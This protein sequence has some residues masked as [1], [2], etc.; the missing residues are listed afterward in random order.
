[1]IGKSLP[2]A[3]LLLLLLLLAS[4]PAPG[5]EAASLYPP[6]PN[7]LGAAP[8]YR[9]VVAPRGALTRPDDPDFLAELERQ[10]RA[11]APHL[12]R[13]SGPTPAS[14]TG[15][16]AVTLVWEGKDPTG[17]LERARITAGIWGDRLVMLI[18]R[19]SAI[20]LR[21]HE[22]T[23]D[24]IVATIA[25]E[26]AS[27]PIAGKYVSDQMTVVLEK[28]A[29]GYGGRIEFAGQAM[30]LTAKAEGN[31]IEGSFETGGNRFPFTAVLEGDRLTLVSGGT[32]YALTREGGPAPGPAN[33]LA[34]GGPAAPVAPAPAP[35]GGVPTAL[36]DLGPPRADPKREWTI[37]VYLD[38]DNDLE[39]FA[40]RDIVE[41]EAGLPPSGI[42]V[43]VLVDRAKGFED[44]LGDWTDSRVYRVRPDVDPNRIASEVLA[45]PGELNMGDPKTL[46]TFMGAALRAFP[47]PN[48]MLI[49]WDHG[50]G[51]ASMASDFDAPGSAEGNDHLTL[52]EAAAGIRGGLARAG[53]EKLDM[54]GF[55]MCLMSQIE[56]AVELEG[57]A[58]VMVASQAIEPGNGWPYN[59]ILPVIAKGT[60]GS[61][62]VAQEIVRAYS[63]FYDAA[64]ADVATLS[65]LDLRVLPEVVAAFD[66]IVG[67]L[68]PAAPAQWPAFSRSI[69]YAEA[70]A[71]R[72]DIRR[73]PQALA[74]VDL[75]DVVKRLRY[76]TEGFA[77]EEEY[78][79]L[80]QAMD[81]F[82][83]ASHNSR[84]RR[85]SN[86]ISI[87][88]PV[89]GEMLDPAWGGTKFGGTSSWGQ[90]LGRIHA[91]Q[92]AGAS[93]PRLT[94]LRATDEK[95]NPIRAVE[96]MNNDR[97]SFD[98]EGNNIV[99]T[100]VWFG[101][102]DPAA[103]GMIV[104]TKGFVVDPLF[105]KRRTDAIADVVDLIMPK[106][107]DG[108]NS[109]YQDTNGLTLR[110]TDG[111]KAYE[112]TMDM[113]ALDDPDHI[114][115][116]VLM[117]HPSVGEFGGTVLFDSYWW[118]AR[119]VIAEIPQ[120][121]GRIAYRQIEPPPETRVTLLLETVTP[122][123]EVKYSRGAT[124]AWGK[125]LEL[126]LDVDA[127][128][129]Y[130]A[131]FIAETIGGQS[132]V[133]TTTF[134]VKE[135]P[136]LERVKGDL[137]QFDAS[138][139]VGTWDHY[140]IGENYQPT[141]LVFEISRH[142]KD[143][144][145]LVAKVTNPK[146]PEVQIRQV[147][148]P[149][150]RLLPSI[151][152]FE[153]D[154]KGNQIGFYIAACGYGV[155][156]GKETFFYKMADVTR[157]SAALVKRAGTGEA[158]GPAAAPAGPAA[159][160]PLLGTWADGM[161][162]TLVFTANVYEYYMDGELA[163]RGTYRIQGNQVGITTATGD[164]ATF[165]FARQ[166]NRLVLQ[167]ETGE[168]MVF[169]KVK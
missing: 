83:L 34:G 87:Y 127:P 167:D 126:L 12:L 17:L 148:W 94:N 14:V 47:A 57:L 142:E 125:G 26:A 168:Q 97:L 141:G 59:E 121:D 25:A 84:R 44:G 131:A 99:W 21:A 160:N 103:G 9:L 162:T 53:L 91:A 140:L 61:R 146:R 111:S 58:D 42:D 8:V 65:A 16:Q 11:T 78:R 108:K 150:R 74:S 134:E 31:R 124:F 18:A 2:G 4:G 102:D 129:T 5:Q 113:S 104:L 115:V 55:D 68:L 88:A 158:A 37:L 166:G 76:S 95:G 43:I 132:T 105:Y 154:D 163:D 29:G 144:D 39:P 101:R 145:L 86:G 50:G 38:G 54:I 60:L 137:G 152:F 120:P 46:E 110:V 51:W 28:T 136:W 70:Y 149:D 138:T 19:S 139:L 23:L 92:K 41:M 56:T 67:K 153:Y 116:P 98:L 63:R 77:G 118:Q 81:G 164:T 71:E 169:Q 130:R 3:A 147:L 151:R 30:P 33:P 82:V 7:P 6:N 45:S 22:R 157:M 20:V 66:G 89:H 79:R 165:T 123:G 128:G 122:A 133:E 40:I 1:M 24:A 13:V 49:L 80:V 15:G 161:G 93:K 117:S 62:R 27:D 73:G 143:P 114:R 10:S 85:L 75:L 112:A 69:F 119:S 48:T 64:E 96:P 135:S 35:A 100:Q 72:T 32:T 90:L 156:D 109:L 106:Y 155:R 52:P 159:G 107:V 36:A